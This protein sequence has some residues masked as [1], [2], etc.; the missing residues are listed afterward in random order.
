MTSTSALVISCAKPGCEWKG[1]PAEAP[2]HPCPTPAE[3]A[4]MAEK[5]EAAAARGAQIPQTESSFL[6]PDALAETET[7]LE[8]PA[9]PV[10][11]DP[12][13]GMEGVDG[14]PIADSLADPEKPFQVVWVSEDGTQEVL[15]GSADTED[16]AEAIHEKTAPGKGYVEIRFDRVDDDEAAVGTDATT[17]PDLPA[18]EGAE[19]TTREELE[20]WLLEH[21]SYDGNGIP[22]D[23]TTATYDARLSAI[24]VTIEETASDD[25]AEPELE[26]IEVPADGTLSDEIEG[27]EDAEDVAAE[28]PRPWEIVIA[29]VLEG[30]TGVA[31]YRWLVVGKPHP[32]VADLREA[33]LIGRGTSKGEAE[34]LIEKVAGEGYDGELSIAKTQDVLEAAAE[35]ERRRE[36]VETPDRE[37]EA[38]PEPELDD[39][40]AED[41]DLVQTDD[42]AEQETG[43]ATDDPEPVAEA[44]AQAQAKQP[45]P[46]KTGPKGESLF[47]ASDFDREDLQIPKVDGFQIDRIAIDFGGG[48]MLDRSE[49]TH[50]ELYNRIRM[51]QSLEAWVEVKGAGTGAKPATNR[52]GD[53]DVIV[54]KKTLRVEAL[55]IIRPEE[56]A[57]FE[58]LESVRSVARRAAKAG[59]PHDQIEAALVDALAAIEDEA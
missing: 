49:P 48:V 22:Q 27:D 18:A 33:E 43:T 29:E 35:I 52:D 11:G 42:E 50:V 45:G 57:N 36:L 7:V 20:A 51:G 46:G 40:P 38:S 6:D 47:D 5:A 54:G 19:P 30:Q 56:L 2:S 13:A 3:D 55:R 28:F 14:I 39:E 31:R 1:P 4:T 37:V 8:T 25:D 44:V 16:D 17:V 32:D 58:G 41:A 23:E 34:E 21:G 26:A 9:A 53:L 15:V 59:I 24:M 10:L 12:F